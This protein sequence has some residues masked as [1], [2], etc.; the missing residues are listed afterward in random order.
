MR[1]ILPFVL[2][3]AA[4]QQNPKTQNSITTTQISANELKTINAHRPDVFSFSRHD[5]VKATHLDLEL[6]VN[7]KQKILE[8]FVVVKYTVLNPEAK[9]LVL[10][11]RDLKIKKVEALVEQ[12]N[13]KIQWRKGD[14]I[15]GLGTELIIDL[16]ADH[17]AIKIH[18]QTKP[19][20]SGLQWLEPEK[21]SGKKYPYLFTQSQAIHARSWIPVQDTPSVRLTY[22]AKIQIK[23]GLRVVMSADN[24]NQKTTDGLHV[25]SMNQA[26]PAYL[27]ALAAG[28][29][30]YQ[31]ISEHVT[32]FAEQQDL[33]AA[34]YEFATTE[35]MITATE[36]MYGKYRWG[37]Y[38]LLVLP[39][40]FPFGGMENPKLSHITPTIIA[41]D[42]SLDSLIAHE[43]AHSWSGNLVTNALWQDAW[44]NEGFTSY[45]ESRIVEAV[46]GRERMM[47]EATLAYQ[48][49]LDEMNTLNEDMQKLVNPAST[50]D[51]DD[52]FSA[53]S[54][55]KGRFF[56]E[57]MEQ[58]VG[59]KA[60]DQFLIQ[61]FD[62]FA[63][64]SVSTDEMIKY[65]Q[66]NLIKKHPDKITVQ[67]VNTWLHQPGMPAFFNPPSTLRFDRVKQSANR[68][69]TGIIKATDINT[70]EWITQEWLHFL[71]ALPKQMTFSQLQE[72]D[73][74]LHLTQRQ[75]SEI[76]HDWLLIAINNQYQPAYSRLIDYLTSI[77]RVKLIKPL[78]QAMMQK[79][80]LHN[81]ALNIYQKA[82]PGYHNIAIQ[83]LDV[84]VRLDGTHE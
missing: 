36:S 23:P 81:L 2:F 5:E 1:L 14:T 32:V 77:G 60:F 10:D 64:K 12:K 34:V 80:E 27:I 20:A 58:Q 42:R 59:R 31:K 66:Q 65:L 17:S 55:D 38:D 11:T 50:S 37:Q 57:W 43:L 48:S 9:H 29:I 72:L 78:Y 84:I 71:R 15:A 33:S 62:H 74:A 13:K 26:I 28:N 21:T 18:Y 25:F 51:P 41:G 83:Q 56:L 24:N 67:Q 45:I 63:F 7:F 61:Y 47:M 52:Y 54:Y 6:K 35:A 76:A 8:G 39:P 19:E 3:L 73:T 16:P 79:N 4:C 68:W 22:N 53:V 49:L 69:S 30:E 40:S 82:R 70:T 46:H 75:N 44:L